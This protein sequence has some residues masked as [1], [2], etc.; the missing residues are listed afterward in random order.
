[1]SEDSC[2]GFCVQV[3]KG[4]VDRPG[5]ERDALGPFEFT[6]RWSEL[7]DAHADRECRDCQSGIRAERQGSE[8]HGHARIR[9]KNN[10]TRIHRTMCES[11][12]GLCE[13]SSI[14]SYGTRRRETGNHTN[15]REPR[16][17]D[18]EKTVHRYRL[19]PRGNKI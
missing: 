16:S 9:Y 10:H 8:P 6:T 7:M 12:C 2:D 3:D 13:F 4:F 15:P 1:M 14:R 18:E 19:P 11:N 5:G 17:F